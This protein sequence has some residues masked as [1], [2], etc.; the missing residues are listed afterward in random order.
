M[1]FKKGAVMP[2]HRSRL[3]VFLICSEKM[4]LIASDQILVHGSSAGKLT[5]LKRRAA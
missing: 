2:F 4:V 3:G 5:S 1:N